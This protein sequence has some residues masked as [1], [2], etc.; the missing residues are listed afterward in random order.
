MVVWIRNV[1]LELELEQKFGTSPKD[2]KEDTGR[3]VNRSGAC[4]IEV[5]LHGTQP[6]MAFQG[7]EEEVYP[8]EHYHLKTFSWLWS[9]N[10]RVNKGTQVYNR[11]III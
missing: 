4:M 8:L 11:P 5:T 6:R 1:A 9:R 7:L 10:D 3:Y 2:L